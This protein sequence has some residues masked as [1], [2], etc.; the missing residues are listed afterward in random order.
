[1]MIGRL[2]Y[3]T[4]RGAGVRSDWSNLPL[5]FPR[6]LCTS[7]EAFVEERLGNIV[8]LHAVESLPYAVT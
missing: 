7:A 6:I 2:V 5:V 8:V 4:C 3:L 1:M